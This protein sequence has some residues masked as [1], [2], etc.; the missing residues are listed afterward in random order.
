[1]KQPAI[2]IFL[3]ILFSCT[4]NQIKRENDTIKPDKEILKLSEQFFIKYATNPD[5]A[6]D[7]CFTNNN[8]V[9]HDSLTSLKSQLRSLIKQLGTYYSYEYITFKKITDS[10]ILIRF[11]VKY[12]RQPLRFD[13]IYYKPNKEWHLQHFQFDFDFNS[14]LEEAGQAKLLNE[15]Y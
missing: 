15:N 4:G 13:F 6:I 10:Y 1:M 12:E 5:S 7:L 2:L 11:L 9:A 3:M 8:W 14:E